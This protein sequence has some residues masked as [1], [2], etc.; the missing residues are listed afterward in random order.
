MKKPKSI[1]IGVPIILSVALV[2]IF[3]AFGTADISLAEA[4]KIL[5]TRG[6]AQLTERAASVQ[7][8]IV[9]QVR[10]PRVL[11]AYLSGASLAVCGC[12]YQSAFK[13]PMADPFVL[14]VSSGAALGATLSIVLKMSKNFLGLNITALFAFAGAL[15]TVFIVYAVGSRNGQKSTTTLLLTGL[16]IGQFITAVISILMLMFQENIKDIY[17]WTLGSFAAKSWPQLAIVAVY[18]IIG[19][20][21]MMMHHTSLDVMLMGDE[22]AYLLGLDVHKVRRRI[23]L[24]TSVLAAGVVS[25][26]GI[27]GFVGLITP[28]VV[29][30]FT[31]PKHKRLLTYSAL[32][33]G[34]FLMSADT[35][36]RSLLSQEVPVGIIT[37]IFGAPFFIYLIVKSKR[38]IFS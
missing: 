36:A 2:V 8:M 20:I 37:A 11:I 18:F 35:I 14:G 9:F 13:N 34:I 3:T 4:M 29:R 17:F 7:E 32:V 1:P 30:I 21:L 26:A 23:L 16:A 22:T 24:I 12:G 25:I 27:I 28:H 10:L 31:G 19:F 33:G 38:E 6:I 15:V 5:F